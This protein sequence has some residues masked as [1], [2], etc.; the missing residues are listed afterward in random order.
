M[1]IRCFV[2]IKFTHPT[3][4]VNIFAVALGGNEKATLRARLRVEFLTFVR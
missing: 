3:G 2:K 1:H 4:C